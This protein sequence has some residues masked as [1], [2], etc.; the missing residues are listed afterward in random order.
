MTSTKLLLKML[1]DLQKI[2]DK[3]GMIEVNWYYEEDDETIQET[4][5]IFD[6]LLQIP[7]YLK[8]VKLGD[9]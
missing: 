7:F 5:E 9:T 1:Y 3:G 2:A 4:G 6:A 8:E